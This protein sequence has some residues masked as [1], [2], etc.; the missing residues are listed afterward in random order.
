[1]GPLADQLD[2]DER[3]PLQALETARELDLL[4][5]PFS[6]EWGGGGLGAFEQCQLMEE[7]GGACLATAL[8]M[9]AHLACGQAIQSGGTEEQKQRF[10]YPLAK[11]NKI[12]GYAPPASGELAL[13]AREE[14][15][16]DLEVSGRNHFVINGE[17]A[18]LVVLFA[19]GG[20]GEDS[21][22]AFLLEKGS[23]GVWI[24]PPQK[25]MGVRGLD[26]R[27]LV[28][29][30]VPV[31]AEQV[32]AG[33]DALTRE[34]T[35]ILELML[36]G[37]CLGLAGAAYEASLEFA[38]TREQ[39]GGPIARKGA[40]QAMIAD[41]LVEIEGLRSL[42]Y[43]AAREGDGSGDGMRLAA[44][45]K[46]MGAEVAG[47]VANRAV[48]LHGGSGYVRDF[49]IERMYRDARVARLF[50]VRNESVRRA[51]A[52]EAL[53]ARGTRPSQ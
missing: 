49:P 21:S 2:R 51:L 44:I 4:G 26:T 32:L 13:T 7:V 25:K 34:V 22:T 46:V 43:R 15:G 5:L 19:P 35:G 8:T 38:T 30:A 20:Q 17:I 24:G 14:G 50:P 47:R 18:D 10:L 41:M 3:P 42:V 23:S 28:L 33:G 1:M 40:V 16:A 31:R 11:G 53:E 27:E 29:E 45:S 12:G 9:A 6:P 39:F 48:Q 37:M 36:A 52:L